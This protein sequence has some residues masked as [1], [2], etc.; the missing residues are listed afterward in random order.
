MVA[1]A[2]TNTMMHSSACFGSSSNRGRSRRRTPR[3]ASKS[4]SFTTVRLDSSAPAFWS[5]PE[6]SLTPPDDCSL[7]AVTDGSWTPGGGG[8][9]TDGI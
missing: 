3:S 5:S 6:T 7:L 2:Q 9:G 1:S 8:R 4:S